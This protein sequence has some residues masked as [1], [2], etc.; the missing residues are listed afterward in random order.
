ML[1]LQ[2][3]IEPHYVLDEMKFYEV[4]AIMENLW[5]KDKSSWEQ[6]RLQGYITAQC[7]S[8]KKLSPDD[9]M[10]FPWEK[11]EIHIDTKEEIKAMEEEMKAYT[12]K[13][14]NR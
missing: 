7:N 14:N 4:E 6:A 11:S 9:I 2:A 13:L 8:T 5:M 3:G 10:K 12:E 1:V